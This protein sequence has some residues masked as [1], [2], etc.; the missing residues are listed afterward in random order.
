VAEYGQFKIVFEAIAELMT[1][2]EKP[3]RIYPVKLGLA[4]CF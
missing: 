1:P 2:P 3:D 4:M